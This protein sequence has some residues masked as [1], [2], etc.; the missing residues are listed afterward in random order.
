MA[1]GCCRDTG[2]L[3]GCL[4]SAH[5]AAAD[6]FLEGSAKIQSRYLFPVCCFFEFCA[7]GRSILFAVKDRELMRALA[8]LHANGCVSALKQSTCMTC[9]LCTLPA[10]FGAASQ[11][12]SGEAET[13]VLII[14]FSAV[15][16]MHGVPAVTQSSAAPVPCRHVAAPR[17]QETC[18]HLAGRC[19]Q[20]GTARSPRCRGGD[21]CLVA[22]GCR[23]GF[24]CSTL[25]SGAGQRGWETPPGPVGTGRGGSPGVT[26]RGRDGTGG[27][28]PG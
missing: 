16:R 22:P 17:R 3:E 15:T 25:Q 5:P 8:A 18:G 24:R 11:N 19:H 14:L 1:S 20:R 9:W 7:A 21:P 28:V 10:A 13:N 12:P 4:C 27:F 2:L 23:T 26:S 6:T